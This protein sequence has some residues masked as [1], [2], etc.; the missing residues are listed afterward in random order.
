MYAGGY[1]GSNM[2]LQKINSQ[3]IIE[4]TIN[5]NKL[6]DSFPNSFYINEP[7][8]EA[9]VADIIPDS[10]GNL[11]VIT[12]KS[13]FENNWFG[14]VLKLSASGD[15][16]GFFH[17]YS[18]TLG[19]WGANDFP[20]LPKG[21][22]LYPSKDLLVYTAI[23]DPIYDNHHTVFLFDTLGRINKLKVL[24]GRTEIFLDD[25]IINKDIISLHESPPLYH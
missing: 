20:V 4:W 17:V 3:G 25:L 8:N 13:Y 22:I 18:D 16:L 5:E 2:F 9:R 23:W 10:S 11:Y 15:S 24:P 19:F 7:I 12:S 6:I 14:C 21:A 1:E